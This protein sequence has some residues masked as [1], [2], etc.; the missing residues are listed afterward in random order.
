MSE[1]FKGFDIQDIR[2]GLATN[3][4]EFETNFGRIVTNPYVFSP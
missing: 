1:N 4:Y 3:V 2:N